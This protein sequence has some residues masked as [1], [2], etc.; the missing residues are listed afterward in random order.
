M[1]K[2]CL[3]LIVKTGLLLLGVAGI[4]GC[5]TPSSTQPGPILHVPISSSPYEIADPY[6][7]RA[8]GVPEVEKKKDPSLEKPLKIA[9]LLP[10][11][12]THRALGQA[13][14]QAAEMSLFE[15]E[16]KSSVVLV[17]RDTKGTAK[18]AREAF[19]SAQKENIQ[20]ILG[21]LFSPE[22]QEVKLLAK[23]HHLPMITFSTDLSVLEKGVYT[24]GF[25]PLPQ[26]RRVLKEAQSQGLN[27][28]VA[29][30]P[31]QAYGD[32]LDQELSRLR[33][34]EHLSVRTV[35]RYRAEKMTS[36]KATLQELEPA[37]ETLKKGS[38]DAIFIP[39][40]G[41][42]L[43]K[44]TFILT[45]EGFSPRHVYFLGTG[46][47]DAVETL[48]DPLLENAWFAAPDPAGRQ[49]FEK[50]FKQV[51]RLT[52]PRLTTLVYDGVALV[53]TLEQVPGGFSVEN[54]GISQG[55]QGV[56][57]VFRFLP[58]GLIERNFCVFVIRKNSLEEIS[59][60]PTNFDEADTKI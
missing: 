11:S 25:L 28:I 6:G 47:W 33:E 10:L 31:Q 19:L 52:P 34:K 44:I 46:Q 58:S 45:K 41:A 4:S 59:P 27:Q 56:D 43:E 36:E 13:L 57:G 51:Y 22:A 21:P 5:D 29:L 53:K 3:S 42:A 23:H 26:A 8:L 2:K 55:F 9:L 14:L 35:G 16:Q 7:A 15:G 24:L 32:L 20:G 12:G 50:R 38:F 40:G 30:L 18:G 39:E 54:I 60:A 17:V 49:A 37:L 48:R 1:K